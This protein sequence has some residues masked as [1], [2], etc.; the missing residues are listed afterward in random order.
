M[1]SEPEKIPF[2]ERLTGAALVAPIRMARLLPYRWRIPFAAW[3]TTRV[4]APLA[5]Y[6]KRVRE[7]LAL[8]RPDLSQAEIEALA[9][10]VPDNA[11]RNMME[12]YSP[13]F[14]DHARKSPVVGPGLPDVRAARD[15]GRPV[16]FVTGHFGS[17][18]AAR[19][20]MMEQGFNMG[21]FYR[22]MANRPFNAHYV[23][24]MAALSEP[25]FEQ[26]RKGMMQ[27]VKHLRSGGVLAIL[28]DLNA[29]DGVPLDFFGKPALTSLAT[30]EM[31]LKFDALLVPVWGLR[32]ADGIHFTIH[33]ETPIEHSDPVTM[34]REFNARL[35][36]A[37]RDNMEQW[38]W[39]HRR[40]KDG[41]G[42][43][44]DR[45]AD[46]LRELEEKA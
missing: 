38:F 25:M 46:Y 41:T 32:D 19:M 23:R 1:S 34:T 33:T 17:F 15:A 44:A 21:V 36:A 9:R 22:P 3:L 42:P 29:H 26:G 18:N 20:A 11:G 31:A 2:G 4:L 10:R 14:P 7:N 40:W 30:A 8:V 45:G 27:M 12:L 43:L 39:I 28:N 13:E 24:A 5:G 16:I 35:E 37:V 6:R